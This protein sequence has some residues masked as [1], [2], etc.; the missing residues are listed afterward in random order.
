M[1][2]FMLDSDTLSQKELDELQSMIQKKRR[3]SKSPAKE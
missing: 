2:Q 1:M 3:Q